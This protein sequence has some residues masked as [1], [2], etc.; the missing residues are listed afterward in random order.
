M[1]HPVFISWDNKNVDH[2]KGAD[3]PKARPDWL[4]MMKFHKI[5]FFHILIW[6]Y[7]Y[8]KITKIKF[9]F[10]I[11]KVFKIVLDSMDVYICF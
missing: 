4:Q 7:I 9:T 3:P 8:F 5:F 6:E 1:L 11:Y 2:I 10:G